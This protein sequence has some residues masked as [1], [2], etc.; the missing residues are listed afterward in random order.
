MKKYLP[1]LDE[2]IPGV[3]I[4]V[5]GLVVWT[6]LAAPVAKLTSKLMPAKAA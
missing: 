4:I 1:S 2:I 3:V 6:F 5:I